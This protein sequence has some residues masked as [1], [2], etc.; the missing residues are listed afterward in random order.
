M[1]VFKQFN[2]GSTC[3]ANALFQQFFMTPEIRYS[4]LNLTIEPNTYEHTVLPEIKKMFSYLQESERQYYDPTE[5]FLIGH[6][7]Q[8]LIFLN[9]KMQNNF[10]VF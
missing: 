10:I 8:R 1:I 6:F 9:N 7:I 4:I 3:Y 5:F 2:M